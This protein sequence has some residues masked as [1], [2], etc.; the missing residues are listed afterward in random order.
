MLVLTEPARW[1]DEDWYPG[2]GAADF[3]H[4]PVPDDLEPWNKGSSWYV[5]LLEFSR[6]LLQPLPLF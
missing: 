2:E 5:A 6:L 4:R 1:G 3:R